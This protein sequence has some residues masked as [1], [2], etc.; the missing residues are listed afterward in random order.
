VSFPFTSF[1]SSRHLQCTGTAIRVSRMSCGPGR[2]AQGLPGRCGCARCRQA[3]P[4]AVVRARTHTN[5]RAQRRA[6]THTSTRARA[7][8][9]KHPRTEKPAVGSHATCAAAL[10]SGSP[11][12]PSSLSTQFWTVENCQ[13]S[14]PTN[15]GHCFRVPRDSQGLWGPH[16]QYLSEPWAPGHAVLCVWKPER[17]S[18][19]Q[20]KCHAR[21]LS[22]RFSRSQSQSSRPYVW[23]VGL[24]QQ[25]A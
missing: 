1:L 13:P 19:T 25:I 9:H 5:T 14:N 23:G 24:T 18:F 11:P 15:F 6:H 3:R 20:S 22:V 2:C 8:T 17:R 7:H 4:A 10:P 12:A 16:E 21:L